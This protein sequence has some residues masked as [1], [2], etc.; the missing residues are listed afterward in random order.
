MAPPAVLIV[1]AGAIALVARR[2][3]AAVDEVAAAQRRVRRVE[4]ALIPV[5]VESRRAGRSLDGFDRR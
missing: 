3:V 5:R 2:I 4:D 1:G